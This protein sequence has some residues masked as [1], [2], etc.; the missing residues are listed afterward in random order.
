V[1]TIQ[2]YLIRH[3]VAAAR[4][5]Y[6]VDAQRPL[7]LQGQHKTQRIAQRLNTLQIHFDLILTSPL[8][9]ARQT[10]EIFQA[11]GLGFEIEESSTLIPGGSFDQWLMWLKAW[12]CS[13][14]RALALVGH[15]PDLCQWAESLIWGE[16]KQVLELK[17]AG[18]IG[19]T[20]PS[21]VSPVGNSQLFWLTPPRLLL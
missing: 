9:R 18:V 14:Q 6:T 5:E 17:K 3:G 10:A 20:L 1:K 21:Q 12:Q 7:T 11:K 8:A 2:L 4:E 13:G 19:L 15:Q 16:A